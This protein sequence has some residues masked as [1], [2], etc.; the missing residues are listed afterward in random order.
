MQSFI[1]AES[2]K[3]RDA[4]KRAVH[5]LHTVLVVLTKFIMGL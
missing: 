2:L 5:S 1:M 4:C 3:Y